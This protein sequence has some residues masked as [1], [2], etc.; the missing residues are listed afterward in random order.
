MHAADRMLQFVTQ[1]D[2]KDKMRFNKIMFITFDLIE[3]FPWLQQFLNLLSTL[4]GQITFTNHEN[5]L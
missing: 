4:I 3:L 2:Q 1:I 5:D